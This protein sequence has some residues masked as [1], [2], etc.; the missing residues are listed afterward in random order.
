MTAALG[1]SR[2]RPGLFVEA[3]QAAAMDPTLR[4]QA[5]VLAAANL[6]GALGEKPRTADLRG[7]DAGRCKLELWAELQGELTIPPDVATQIDRFDEG[8][9]LAL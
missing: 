5:A 3:I 2:I 8:G 4:A 7:S 1:Q 6:P 9:V